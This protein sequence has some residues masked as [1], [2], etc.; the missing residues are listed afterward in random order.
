MRAAVAEGGRIAVREVAAPEPGPG[1]A[2]LRVLACGVCGSDLHHF[3]GRAA[4]AAPLVYGHE[5]AAEVAAYG[6]GASGPA[7]GTRVV[8]VPQAGG[9]IV[10]LSERYPGGFAEQ[11]VVAADMLIPVPPHVPTG[12]AALTEPLAVGAHAVAAAPAT[13]EAAL[14]IGCGPIGLAVIAALTS[15]ASAPYVIAADLSDARRELARRMGADEVVDPRA[16]DPYGRLGARVTAAEAPGGSLRGDRTEPGAVVFECVGV[17]GM[18]QQVF[19]GAP[20]GAR[21]VVAGACMEPD[22]T[23]PVVALVKE[24]TVAYVFGY[25]RA[26]FA[27]TLDAIASGAV[28]PGPL[29]TGRVGLDGVADAFTALADPERHA[30][31]LVHP[32]EATP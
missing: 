17:P 15:A 12:H 11:A 5:F 2:L 18:I 16:G 9:E 22:T 10:G 25:T 3:A 32:Q 19:A 1:E 28:D 13:A 14:V 7:A 23:V 8:A 27:A 4:D 26:E 6:P 31:I 29:I 20:P 24:L 21:V 30:K